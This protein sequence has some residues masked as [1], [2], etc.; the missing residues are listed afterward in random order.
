MFNQV[1]QQIKNVEC[2]QGNVPMRR[3]F[4]FSSSFPFI[5]Q[6]REKLCNR[7]SK[8]SKKKN[9]FFYYLFVFFIAFNQLK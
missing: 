3:L 4:F 2:N 5:I 7:K 8:P 1:L 6:V 9:E